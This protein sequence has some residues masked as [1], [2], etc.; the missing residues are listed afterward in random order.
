MKQRWTKLLTISFALLIMWAGTGVAATQ[1]SDEVKSS[2]MHAAETTAGGHDDQTTV[3]YG[4]SASKVEFKG[5]SVKLVNMAAAQELDRSRNRDIS[6]K[7]ASM[8]VE[9]EGQQMFFALAVILIVLMIL[10]TVAVKSKAYDSTSFPLRSRRI[11]RV[12][13][14]LILFLAVIKSDPG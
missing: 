10:G 1:G 13:A 7:E 6:V 4:G 12:W 14:D 3:G 2:P 9:S 11:V 5:D 8:N